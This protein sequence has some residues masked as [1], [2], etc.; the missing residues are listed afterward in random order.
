V[1]KPRQAATQVH[2]D[3]EVYVSLAGLIDV[4]KEIERLQKQQAEKARALQATRARLAN[5]SFV[6]R[7]APDVVQQA[8][9][10]AA[11]LEGQLRIIEETL[12]DLREG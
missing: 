6:E 8:R 5:P 10:Q 12:K 2:A 1:T 7:A 3:F 9:D 11:E 4:T